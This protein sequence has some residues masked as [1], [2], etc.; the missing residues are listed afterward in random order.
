MLH[1]VFML[2]SQLKF[3]VKL[4]ININTTVDLVDL[5]QHLLSINQETIGIITILWFLKVERIK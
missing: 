4:P 3:L 1:N 5:Q 2:G